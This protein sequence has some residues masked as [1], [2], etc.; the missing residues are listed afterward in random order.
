M[1]L[2]AIL[3]N[4]EEARTKACA[5]CASAP[6]HERSAF[7]NKLAVVARQTAAAIASAEAAAQDT[8]ARST[9][10]G[11]ACIALSLLRVEAAKSCL[12][13]IADEGSAAVKR[14]L[15]LALRETTT[16]EGRSVLVY[17]L[18]D[19]DARDDAILAIGEKPWPAVLPLLIEVAEADEHSARLAARGI[20]RCGATAGPDETNAAADFLLEQL[21]DEALQAVAVDALLRFG[22]TFPGVADKAKRLAKEPGSRKAV[23]L[24]LVAGVDEGNAGL[25]ELALSGAKADPEACRKFLA[26]LLADADERVRSAAERT[27]K[28]LD[29]R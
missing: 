5:A 27:L 28:A 26:P 13:R 3:G 2:E 11:R 29:L 1:R 21:D 19:D 24:C 18:S 10:L 17:L 7:A 20:A 8:K 25:L 22:S 23:G 6:E 16:T 9:E 14:T 15:S 4:D 12:L